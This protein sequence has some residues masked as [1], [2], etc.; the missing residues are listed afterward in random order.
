APSDF[1]SALVPPVAPSIHRRADFRH[2]QQPAGT[3][4]GIVHPPPRWRTRILHQEGG[5]LLPGPP[6]GDFG[7]V[8]I[9]GNDG[10]GHGYLTSTSKPCDVSLPKISITL[11]RTW[12]LAGFS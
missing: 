11:T 1:G 7:Q 5:R 6:T 4:T 12:Y 2:E 3:P 9:V 8:P 10:F